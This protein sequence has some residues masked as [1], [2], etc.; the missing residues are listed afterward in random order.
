MTWQTNVDGNP[1][2]GW[3][4]DVHDGEQ[5]GTYHPDAPNAWEAAAKAKEMHTEAT[6][7]SE[8][9]NDNGSGTKTAAETERDAVRADL[10]ALKQ[11]AATLSERLDKAVADIAG[12]VERLEAL[13]S[14]VGVLEQPAPAAPQSADPDP[15]P[16]PQPEPEATHE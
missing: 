14:R 4:V 10:D 3:I 6:G 2:G 12:A 9:A 16:Q 11:T 1:E 15:E 5:A 8:T 13:A 7:R